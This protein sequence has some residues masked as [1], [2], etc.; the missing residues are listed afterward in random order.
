[1]PHRSKYFKM[2]SPKYEKLQKLVESP[3]YKKSM[4]NGILEKLLQNDKEKYLKFQ[5][6]IQEQLEK[7]YQESLVEQLKNLPK[8]ESLKKTIWRIFKIIKSLSST[9][10]FENT[11]FCF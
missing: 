2:L 10:K 3:F 8:I 5:A 4:A 11:S 7:K 6:R 9:I 1:M